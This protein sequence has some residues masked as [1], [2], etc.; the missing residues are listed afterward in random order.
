MDRGDTEPNPNDDLDGADL[1]KK[2]VILARKAG[3]NIGLSDVDYADGLLDRSF[4][5]GFDCQDWKTDDTKNAFIEMIQNKKDT[6]MKDLIDRNKPLVPR[7]VGTMRPQSDG[8]VKLSVGIQFVK[9]I[10]ELGVA[11][12]NKLVVTVNR[13]NDVVDTR[14]L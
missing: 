13:G 8:T 12:Y 2:L 7:Y 11:Q 5:T 14:V 6:K 10:S 3:Y 4:R 9:A 1:G